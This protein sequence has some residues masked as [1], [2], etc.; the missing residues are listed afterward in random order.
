MK[1]IKKHHI[2]ILTDRMNCDCKWLY[3]ATFKCAGDAVIAEIALNAACS[4]GYHYF[5]TN[6][7]LSLIKINHNTDL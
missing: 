6:Q 4:N 3:V 5:V 1:K 2:F 7:S